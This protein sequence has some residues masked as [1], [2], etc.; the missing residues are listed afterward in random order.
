VTHLPAPVVLPTACGPL[1]ADS[2]QRTEKWM[3]GFTH[4]S[5][6]TGVC[7]GSLPEMPASRTWAKLVGMP[8]GAA[9]VSEVDLSH[10][11][12]EVLLRMSSMDTCSVSGEVSS[13]PSL[14]GVNNGQAPLL[15]YAGGDCFVHVNFIYET[16]G[17]YCFRGRAS[18]RLDVRKLQWAAPPP[19]S[20]VVPAVAVW[21]CTDLVEA[22][23]SGCRIVIEPETEGVRRHL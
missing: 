4:P 7:K 2:L 16:G 12:F 21:R 17:P 18:T 11:N 15:A 22:E 19:A 9:H 23:L 3:G 6:G 20:A 1:R 10:G 8:S 13:P 5:P 14:Q